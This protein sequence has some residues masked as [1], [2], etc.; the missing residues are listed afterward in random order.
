MTNPTNSYSAIT[1]ITTE[2]VNKFQKKAEKK[3]ANIRYQKYPKDLRLFLKHINLKTTQFD[4]SQV[5]HSFLKLLTETELSEENRNLNIL[6]LKKFR[7]VHGLPSEVF[8]K[9]LRLVITS[10]DS[11]EKIALPFSSYLIR[12]SYPFLE[13][14]LKKGTSKTKNEIYLGSFSKE[15]LELFQRFLFSGKITPSTDAQASSAAL[16]ELIFFA[17]FL[18]DSEL[19]SK[20]IDYLFEAYFDPKEEQNFDSE[21]FKECGREFT[22]RYL[23]NKA[24]SFGRYN[25]QSFEIGLNDFISLFS[26]QNSKVLPFIRHFI[27]GVS[28]EKGEIGKLSLIKGVYRNAIT[29]ISFDP[30]TTPENL[31]LAADFKVLKYCFPNAEFENAFLANLIFQEEGSKTL[32]HYV[33]GLLDLS[34]GKL[35]SAEENFERVLTRKPD[36]IPTHTRLALLCNSPTSTEYL[37]KKQRKDLKNGLLC[38]TLGLL[39]KS[40]PDMASFYLQEGLKKHPKHGGALLELV[41]LFNK[42]QNFQNV[43]K[44]FLKLL[45]LNFDLSISPELAFELVPSLDSPKAQ[46]LALNYLWSALKSYPKNSLLLALIGEIFRKQKKFH[47]AEYYLTRASKI[48]KEAP[49]LVSLAQTQSEMG[50]TSAKEQFQLAVRFNPNNISAHLAYGK[51][52]EAMQGDLDE[53]LKLYLTA[54]SL[55]PKY[56]ESGSIL[57]DFL[58]KYTSEKFQDEYLEEEDGLL[59]ALD[60]IDKPQMVETIFE[61][62]KSKTTFRSKDL[63]LK[64]RRIQEPLSLEN[65][66]QKDIDN[67]GISYEN[68]EEEGSESQNCGQTKVDLSNERKS[69][70]NSE[71]KGCGS[72]NS[73]YETTQIL[74]HPAPN[75]QKRKRDAMEDGTKENVNSDK[76]KAGSSELN[77]IF[78][79]NNRI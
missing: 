6:I 49:I 73:G 55:N 13:N 21:I 2:T 5:Y 30:N 72:Q 27:D 39:S 67:E 38:I 25:N 17:R 45:K 15:F 14:Y 33:T 58:I 32:L 7:E 77:K 42:E 78:C 48:S 28:W 50:L 68:S 18:E 31:P 23:Q 57:S 9:D 24:I 63:L 44:T 26:R 59:A 65:V 71:E 12:R 4:S 1:I 62:I 10:K 74:Q 79:I 64:R 61:L 53:I 16:S 69:Y 8:R 76:G 20:A 47:E 41:F 46:N 43:K 19:E 37:I 11:G 22:E 3:R 51:Y 75:P 40:T 35:A 56:T 52:L 36:N 70:E 29:F 34:E 60:L 66:D 54:Y